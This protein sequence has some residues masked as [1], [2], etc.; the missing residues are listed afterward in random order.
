[1]GMALQLGAILAV[2]VLI[3]YGFH[4]LALKIERDGGVLYDESSRRRGQVGNALLEVQSILEPDK[5][6]LLE[7]RRAELSEEDDEGDPPE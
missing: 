1:M 4:R 2:T 6:H 7:E 5:Q 3:L